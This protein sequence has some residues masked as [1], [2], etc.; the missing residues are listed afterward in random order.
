MEDDLY[1][2]FK[3]ILAKKEKSVH[4][5]QY[6]CILAIAKNIPEPHKVD[7]VVNSHKS[8]NNK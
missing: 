3:P 2:I 1:L 7:F 6:K 4:F 5:D 8:V